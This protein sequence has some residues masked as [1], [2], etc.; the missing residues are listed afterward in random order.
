MLIGEALADDAAKQTIGS[1][2]IVH[3]TRNT[4]VIAELELGKVAV[5]VLFAAELIDT[6]QAYA[7]PAS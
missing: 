7:S 2:G 6:L 3:P 5:K 4:V 1:L